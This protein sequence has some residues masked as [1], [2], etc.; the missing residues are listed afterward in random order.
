MPACVSSASTTPSPLRAQLGDAEVEH[1]DHLA[2]CGGGDAGEEEVV[3]LEVAVNDAFVVRLGER[4]Q[5]LAADAPGLLDGEATA[6]LEPGAEG[7]ADEQLHRQEE[8]GLGGRELV[9]VGIGDLAE[10][11]DG[12][13]VRG[14]EQAHRPRL[15]AEA[16]LGHGALGAV[17]AEDLD[18][19]VPAH[20]LLPGAVHGAHRAR[21]DPTQDDEAAGHRGA[22][23]RIAVGR[24][25][26]FERDEGEA[27]VATAG[28]RAR[29]SGSAP[30]RS[31]G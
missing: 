2:R 14:R 15:A 11:E 9:G 16:R 28:D 27:V 26:R 20:H 31:P 17:R 25:Q 7:L 18:G 12:D 1:L 21:A 6:P 23:E 5:R 3:R 8:R 13:G 10:V 22:E 30:G 24:Q 19:H 29:R 4:Q